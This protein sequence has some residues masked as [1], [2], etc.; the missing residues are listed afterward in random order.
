[1]K[2]EIFYIYLYCNHLEQKPKFY[3]YWNYVNSRR[4]LSS[5]IYHTLKI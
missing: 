4:D 1:M 5:S 3:A 2:P